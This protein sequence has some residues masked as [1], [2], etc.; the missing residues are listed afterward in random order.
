MPYYLNWVRKLHDFYD[1]KPDS[2]IISEDIDQFLKKL[3]STYESW[4]VQQASDA[5]SLYRICQRRKTTTIVQNSDEPARQWKHVADEMVR[6]IRLRHLSIRTE[7]TYMGWIRSYYR[8][9]KGKSPQKLNQTDLKD[10]LTHLA[11]DRKVS[12]STQNQAF[13]SI[14]FLYRHILSIDISDLNDVL[15]AK[16]VKRLPVVLTQSEVA[17]L[18][19]YMDGINLLMAKIIYGGGLRLQE[20]LNLRIK[21]V[22]FRRHRL[23]VRAGKGN[24]DRETLLA[25]QI[26]EDLNNHIRKAWVLFNKDQKNKVPGVYL[27]HALKR[28]YS[29]AGKEWHWQWVFASQKLSVDPRSKI[30]RRHHL[31]PSNLQRAIKRATRRGSISKR[32]TVH[33]LRH[34]FATHLLE[35]G[36]DIR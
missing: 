20:C 18:F 6:M 28:K 14:L 24:K 22:D 8:F 2:P 10:F 4:Q 31:H 32:I 36:Y 33:T 29:N 17:S 12:A 21:D 11:A 25:T 26:K 5:V 23:I 7:K 34:S 30:V 19:Q 1:I 3:S 16:K 15:R 35:S 13:N 27:P 9:L